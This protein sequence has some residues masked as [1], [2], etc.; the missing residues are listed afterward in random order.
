MTTFAAKLPRFA[1]PALACALLASACDDYEY[2]HCEDT[3]FELDA[4]ATTPSGHS[5]AEVLALIEGERQVELRYPGPDPEVSVEHDYVDA[6]PTTLTI[7]LTPALASKLGT[8]SVRWIE[9]EEVYPTS[10]PAP[11]IAIECPDRLEIDAALGFSTLDGAFAELFDVTVAAAI[12]WDGE[13]SEASIDLDYDP[14]EL[15][16][17]LNVGAIE[18]S[19]GRVDH[20]ISLRYALTELAAEQAGAEVGEPRGEVGGGVEEQGDGWVGYYAF[21]IARFGAGS[22]EP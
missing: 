10:G 7:D 3:V 6:E 8:A 19:G 1:L 11:A 22:D 2:P 13:L 14:A 5:V 16:G 20:F 18:P 9:S 15:D 4:D 12:D 17:G 21:V